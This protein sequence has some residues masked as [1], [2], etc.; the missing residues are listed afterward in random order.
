LNFESSHRQSEDIR[1]SNKLILGTVTST[2]DV[3][4][5]LLNTYYYGLGPSS[6]H[7]QIQ[8]FQCN[9][10]IQGLLSQILVVYVDRT[11]RIPFLQGHPSRPLVISTLLVSVIGFVIPYIPK[12]NFALGLVH[13]DGSFLGILAA[14]L[15]LY[16]VVTQLFKMLYIKMFT[17]WL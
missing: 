15:V 7:S 16:A 17:R 9:W 11:A 8:K 5:F 2:I 3:A 13:P 12:L 14:F 10:F 1:F 6:D 4:T